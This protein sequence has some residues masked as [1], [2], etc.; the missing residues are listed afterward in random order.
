MAIATA[1]PLL[2]SGRSALEFG[3]KQTLRLLE[4]VP[5]AGLGHRP[6]PTANHVIWL[7][8]HLAWTEN[9][10]LTGVGGKPVLDDTW[11][12]NFATGTKPRDDVKG[13]PSLT[14]IR[15]ALDKTRKAL[16][17][18]FAK[19]NEQQLLKPP[20]EPLKMFGPTH[21]ALLG[22][23]AWHEGYHSGQISNVRRS[24]GLPYTMG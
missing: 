16:L 22:S 6:T 13:Y 11:K 3:R 4:G 24:L 8:G 23:L 18:W 9:E 17:D 19:L 5:P 21:A 1:S 12:K 15:A 7:L 20:P 10:F 2:E 14:E